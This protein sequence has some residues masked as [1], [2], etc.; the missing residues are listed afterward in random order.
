MCTFKI[1]NDPRDSEVDLLLKL[2]GPTLRQSLKLDKIYFTHH[3]LS[4]TG[5]ISPQ[6]VKSGDC[7]YMLLGEIYNYDTSLRSDIY[8]VIEMYEKHKENFTKY[9]DGEFLVIVYDTNSK[10]IHFFTDPWSTRQA[11][12]ETYDD[13]FYFGT[14]PK[15]EI[16]DRFERWGFYGVNNLLRLKHNSHYIF[17][18][19]DRKLV[20]V[21]D[22]LHK[23]DLR[24][25]HY[26]Y[27]NYI[28][29]LENAVLKRYHKDA[30]VC[31]SGGLDSS[32]VAL[33]LAENKLPFTSLTLNI[34]NAE[35]QE[36]LH[37][38]LEYTKEYNISNIYTDY[39][40]IDHKE[41]LEKYKFENIAI[42]QMAQHAKSLGKKVVIQGNG[43][44]E[45]FSNYLEN[46]RKGDKKV[47]PEDLFS[48]FPWKHFY[49][50]QNRRLIDKKELI[51]L[52][53]GLELRNL[54]LDK[55][56]VQAWLNLSFELKNNF[57]GGQIEYLNRKGIPLPKKIA[58]SV[59][60]EKR[61]P[62]PVN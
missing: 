48:I 32:I 36:T 17:Y 10:N 43:F 28:S 54:F 1:T 60:Q 35:D 22:E 34:T 50:G 18:T 21:N 56:F 16:Y 42:T 27:D 3:L 40:D 24:Q 26:S 37:S 29:K 12:Y 2:G 31:L 8:Y 23:W 13:H 57:K 38:V 33:C 62:P 11:W 53:Y 39:V 55:E 47:W 30:V 51:F 45:I 46:G 20:Q 58:S 49:D 4:V 5:Q 52:T 6:P 19:D 14:Y 15:N 61:L 59:N 25:N 7:Y 44:D 9:L 41:I